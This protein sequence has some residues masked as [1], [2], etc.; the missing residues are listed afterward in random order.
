MELAALRE[1][2]DT[3]NE[4]SFADPDGKKAVLGVTSGLKLPSEPLSSVS[5]AEKI[6]TMIDCYYTGGAKHRLIEQEMEKR[7]RP[8]LEAAGMQPS[9]IRSWDRLPREQEAELRRTVA[10]EVA[11]PRLGLVDAGGQ[12]QHPAGQRMLETA[13]R[14]GFIAAVTAAFAL[15]LKPQHFWLLI[16]QAV[17][18]H[19]DLHAETVRKSWVAHEGKK[20]L[21]VRCDEFTLGSS[22]NW[23]T[24]V[25]GK[26]DSFA[27]QIAANTVEGVAEVLSPGFSGTTA[28]EDIAQKV[29]VMD[30]CKNFFSYRCRTLCGGH[31]RGL[32]A[33]SCGGG[34]DARS[35]RAGLR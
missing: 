1:Q 8:L 33:P 25:S 28:A 27:A 24:V 13:H 3:A 9:R 29:V 21:E 14:H 30:I 10:A 19:V 17:A 16:S 32:G 18:T 35:L 2:F 20:T 34:A 31:R 5:T 11:V 12:C 7:R 15:A 22:N 23:A 26:S 4:T 6:A